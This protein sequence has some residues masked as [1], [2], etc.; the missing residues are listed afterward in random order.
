[1]A[2]QFG[3]PDERPAVSA[4]GYDGPRLASTA[5]VER[6]GALLGLLAALPDG[7]EVFESGALA[8]VGIGGGFFGGNQGG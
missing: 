1:V 8:G 3:A 5:T 6:A 2:W 4:R 7:F